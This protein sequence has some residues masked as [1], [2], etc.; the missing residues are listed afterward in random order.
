MRTHNHASSMKVRLA[1]IFLGAFVAAFV[2]LNIRYVYANIRYAVAPGTIKTSDSLS[3]A[4][5]LLPLAQDVAAKPLPPSARLVIDSIGVNTP[6]VFDVPPDNK[7]I[8]NSLEKGVVHYSTSVKPGKAGVSVILGHSSAYP[9]Y[10]GKYGSVFALLNKLVPGSKFYIQY[11]DGRV[12]VFTVKRS[13]VFNPFTDEARLAEL[14]Q[15]TNPSIVLVSCWPVGTNYRRIA[16][17][18]EL[19]ETPAADRV[20]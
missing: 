10:K 4:V 16:V 9:W 8:Y 19:A 11:A 1:A 2:I 15:N 18:A 12:F 14:E 3:Q 20:K 5:R 17:Q 6:I 7:K 13:L